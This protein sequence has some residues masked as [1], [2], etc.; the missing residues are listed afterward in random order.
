V[1]SKP[2]STV[3]AKFNLPSGGL[4]TLQSSYTVSQSNAA[5]PIFWGTALLNDGGYTYIY[6][7]E[8]QFNAS[9][10]LTGRRLHIARVPTG[11]FDGTWEQV[12]DLA[13][14]N[15]VFSEFS[16]AKLGSTYLLVTQD[17]G[18]HVVAYASSTPSSFSGTRRSC[19]PSPTTSLCCPG[20]PRGC[21][22]R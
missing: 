18:N 2:T 1:Y 20:T 21:S 17:Y 16:V 8:D 9:C 7:S 6:G 19:T 4:P 13:M 3:V 15:G 10:A 14:P 11:Q 22:P 5:S 12:A